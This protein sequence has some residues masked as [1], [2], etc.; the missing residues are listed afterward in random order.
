MA[1]KKTKGLGKTIK[2]FIGLVAMGA[3]SWLVS[4]DIRDWFLAHNISGTMRW[5]A[6]FLIVAVIVI[7]FKLQGP[8][9]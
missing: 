7:G 9:F 3:A 6:A 1:K 2:V 5:F 8:D 4:P